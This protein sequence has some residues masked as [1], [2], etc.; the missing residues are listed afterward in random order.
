MNGRV[1]FGIRIERRWSIL[2]RQ[3]QMNILQKA[4]TAVPLQYPV[5]SYVGEHFLLNLPPSS[6]DPNSLSLDGLSPQRALNA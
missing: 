5:S 4:D 1:R 6:F 2:G 3:L